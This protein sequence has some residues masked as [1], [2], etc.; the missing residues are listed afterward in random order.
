MYFS[1]SYFSKVSQPSVTFLL[2]TSQIPLLFAVL[3]SVKEP[4]SMK[5]YFTLILMIRLKEKFSL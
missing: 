4:K 2:K 3:I 1:L 5:E